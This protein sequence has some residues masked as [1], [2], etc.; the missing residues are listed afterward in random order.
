MSNQAQIPNKKIC[1][2]IISFKIYCPPSADPPQAE[3]LKIRN[4]KFNF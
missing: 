3:K 4:L 2:K 1:L